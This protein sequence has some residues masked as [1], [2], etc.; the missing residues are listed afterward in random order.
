MTYT[1][2]QITEIL[3]QAR[4][5]ES[6]TIPTTKIAQQLNIPW[7]TLLEHTIQHKELFLSLGTAL[8]ELNYDQFCLLRYISKPGSEDEVLVYFKILNQYR[9]A[10]DMAN[11]LNE[12]A[13]DMEA[14][15][16][17]AAEPC[18]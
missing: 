5:W 8:S 7:G 13:K 10:R 3:Q 14:A 1:N 15:Q 2:S 6:F 12:R 17:L 9:H 4:A 16:A 11:T 18:W